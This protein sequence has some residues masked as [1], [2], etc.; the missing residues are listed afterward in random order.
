MKRALVLGIVAATFAWALPVVAQKDEN[1]A[2]FHHELRGKIVHLDRAKDEFTINTDD[3]KTV[4]CV[5]SSQTVFK[6]T[7]GKRIKFSNLQPGDR[8]YCHCREMR[9]GKHYSVYLLVQTK[10]QRQA[11]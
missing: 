10:H 6:N 5:V 7:A 11:R 3:G 2:R 1:A 9:D 8:A 4:E